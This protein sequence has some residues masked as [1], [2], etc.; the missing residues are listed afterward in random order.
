MLFGNRRLTGSFGRRSAACAAI[1]AIAVGSLTSPPAHGQ[2]AS[3][4]VGARPD[5]P[6]ARTALAAAASASDGGLSRYPSAVQG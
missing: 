1:V 2:Q 6:A 3:P 5:A 4:G